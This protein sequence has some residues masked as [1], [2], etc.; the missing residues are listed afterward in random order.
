MHRHWWMYLI[1]GV[2]SP[3]LPEGS[4]LGLGEFNA[5]RHVVVLLQSLLK[6]G[7]RRSIN[8]TRGSIVARHNPSAVVGAEQSQFSISVDKKAGTIPFLFL[9]LAY[10]MSPAGCDARGAD[11]AISAGRLRGM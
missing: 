2:W 11:S 1:Q 6:S 3:P 5:N 7:K 8:P 4:E 10:W 9:P